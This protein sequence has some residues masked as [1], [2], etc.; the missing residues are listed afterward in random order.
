MKKQDNIIAI[1]GPTASGKTDLAARLAQDFDTEIISADSRLVF[2]EFNIGVAKPSQEE[3][4][5]VK[6]HLVDVVSPLEDFSVSDFKNLA[7]KVIEKLFEQNKTPIVAGGTGFYIKSLLE[8]L[9]IPKVPADEGFR[10]EMRTLAKDHGNEY[11]YRILIEKDPAM[12]QKL[13]YND[14]FRVIRALEVIKSLNIPMSEAQKLNKPDFNVIYIGL[15]AKDRAFLY[16]RVNKRVDLMVEQGLFEEVEFLVKKYGE[17][18][19]LLKTLGYKEVI[20]YFNN[21]LT[22]EE[23]VELIKKNTRNFA[24]RQLTWFRTNKNINWFYIDENDNK[25]LTQKVREKCL[26]MM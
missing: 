24:K 22:K 4:A 3:L 1:T 19:S 14:I 5:L 25:N 9:D 8:G 17:T 15:D 26:S 21:R 23:A 12:A 10:A 7:N 16:D 13:H 20:D 18:V 6:H 11:L 2:R